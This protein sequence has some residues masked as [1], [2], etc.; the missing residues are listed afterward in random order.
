MSR[1]ARIKLFAMSH[2]MVERELDRVER[3][4]DIDLKRDESAEDVDDQYYPQFSEAVRK[5]AASMA[6]HYEVFYSLERSIR[7]LIKETLQARH[8][9][10]WW[11][12]AVP[13]N[14]QQSAREN[15]QREL[16]SGVT[17]RSVDEIDYITFG[18]LGEIVR[19]N[20]PDF[21]DTFNNEKAFTKIMNSLNV[22]RGPIAHSSPLAPDEVVRLRL[23]L[24]D[25]FRLME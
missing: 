14:V 7:E 10:T 15:M 20:W 23:T 24:K 4:L 1:E 2:Q 22:L 18:E 19:R 17:A 12:T 11:D 21:N 9:A 6:S 3:E 5:E 8:G 13:A 25:W 16:E